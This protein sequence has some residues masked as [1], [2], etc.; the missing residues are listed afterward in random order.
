M[1]TYTFCGL[2]TRFFTIVLF[3][4]GLGLLVAQNQLTL[5]Y[6]ESF[7]GGLVKFTQNTSD[8]LDWT[9]KSGA[10]N[11]GG[12]TGPSS[13]HHGSRYV[14]T[15]AHNHYN[16]T[17][18]LNFNSFTVEDSVSELQLSFS[19]HMFGGA[20]MGTLSL[21]IQQDDD[22][23]TTLWSKSGNQ[24]NVWY[25]A[26]ISLDDYLD[27]EIKL[28]FSGT[29]GNGWGSYMAIDYFRIQEEFILPTIS[30][31]L[32]GSL[33]LN[34]NAK[35]E[36]STKFSEDMAL[37]TVEEFLATK[38][39]RVGSNSNIVTAE[40][41]ELVSIRYGETDG[42]E[43]KSILIFEIEV[44]AGHESYSIHMQY[45]DI[46]HNNSGLTDL[47][48]NAFEGQNV[49]NASVNTIS[50][51]VATLSK[52]GV[53][54]YPNPAKSELQLKYA[55][56]THAEYTIY[57]LTGQ[58]MATAQHSH[59]VHSINVSHLSSGTYL[60]QAKSDKGEKYYHFIKE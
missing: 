27:N 39:L 12:H 48:G 45:G 36:W 5:P 30:N 55:Y 32:F 4:T 47:A 41:G 11:S 46:G 38:A 56:P 17:T 35:A 37:P 34:A 1:N 57:S 13:A 29:M 14:Y 42:Q 49:A 43:D 26:E 19:Y 9:R 28:R 18:I 23:W 44:E 20:A 21:Q 31:T 59:F 54:L 60:L 52:Q 6:T 22:S 16:E 51:S 25:T 40:S 33:V 7:E 3:L 50:L 53:L 2:S 8:D 24:G 15:H 58:V 10:A